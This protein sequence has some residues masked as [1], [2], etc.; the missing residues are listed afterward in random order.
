MPIAKP[1]TSLL[2]LRERLV[3][4]FAIGNKVFY[5]LPFK[6]ASSSWSLIV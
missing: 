4:G 5:Q 3:K 1:L 2:L 6:K